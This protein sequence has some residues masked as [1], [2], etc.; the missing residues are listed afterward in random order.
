MAFK[1]GKGNVW[2]KKDA[3][4][5]RL[6]AEI[7]RLHDVKY[8]RQFAEEIQRNIGTML[9]VTPYSKWP[10]MAKVAYRHAQERQET[11]AWIYRKYC[12]LEEAE[13]KR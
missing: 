13:T 1:T 2:A 11:A 10:E 8:I 5:V 3:E 12:A 7:E 6:K 4:I 9:A